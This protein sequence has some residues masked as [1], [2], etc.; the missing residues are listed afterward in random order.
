M[1]STMPAFGTE[2]TYSPDNL[3][4]NGPVGHDTEEVT[5]LSGQNLARGAVLGKQAVSVVPA[6]G[7]ADAGNTGNG[8]MGSVARGGENLKAG[9]YTARCIEAAT[10]AGTFE[11]IDPDGVVVG[12]ATV[13]VAFTSTHLDFTIADG[14]TDFAV[15][16]LFTVAVSGAG[17]F[18]LSATAAA[19]GSH[20][21]H[22]ILAEDCDASA[23]DETA[24]VYKA[25]GFNQRALTFGT[26]H[27]AATVKDDLQAENMYLYA[28][29]GG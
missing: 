13:A 17:K 23:G 3:L 11:V 7:T 9:T 15:G 8:T 28:S 19:D 10:N 4:V 25:G 22:R 1:T 16:D 14:S 27:S 18:L 21:A 5:L 29:V 6:T 26:G 24:L 12:L 2:G 20:K